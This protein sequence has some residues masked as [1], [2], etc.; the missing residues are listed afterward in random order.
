MVPYYWGK[1][2]QIGRRFITV[3]SRWSWVACG[4]AMLLGN[5]IA[6]G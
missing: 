1:Q 4:G 5:V 6:D 3:A 2:L